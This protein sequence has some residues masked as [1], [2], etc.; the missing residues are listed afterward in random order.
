[1]VKE[2]IPAGLESEEYIP[3]EG[4]VYQRPVVSVSQ[5][6]TNPIKGVGL[7]V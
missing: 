7:V 6:N 2:Q 5:H 1:M 4:H 3:V